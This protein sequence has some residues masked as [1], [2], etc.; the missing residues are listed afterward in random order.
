MVGGLWGWGVGW[1]GE[2]EVR[3]KGCLAGERGGSVW[4]KI[5]KSLDLEGVLSRIFCL[6][7]S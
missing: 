3:G 2:V 7:S 4:K 1:V 5:A 6:G